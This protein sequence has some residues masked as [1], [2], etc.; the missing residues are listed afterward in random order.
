MSKS[1]AP[2][3]RRKPQS[4][5]GKDLDLLRETLGIPHESRT[6]VFEYLAHTVGVLFCISGLSPIP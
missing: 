4:F 2:A 6:L 3:A 1:A 5:T